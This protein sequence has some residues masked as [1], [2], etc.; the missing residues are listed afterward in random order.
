M[1][2]VVWLWVAPV[3]VVGLLLAVLA[4]LSGGT[5]RWH[6]GVVESCGGMLAWLLARPLPFSGPV[7]A[8]TLGHVVIA[9]SPQAL[10]E[11]RAHE[12]VHV[13]QFER[14]GV[15]FLAAY[16]LASLWA[17]LDGG[18]PY[19]DNVFEREA[20]ALAARPCQD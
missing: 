20:R 9:A 5:V 10:A 1:R 11:T 17:W 2:L 13:R 14:F 3:T 4:R 15:A 12:R 18:D 19:L 16:P 6:T 7:A 8:M